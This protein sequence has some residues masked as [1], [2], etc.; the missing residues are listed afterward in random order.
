MSEKFLEIR[1]FLF[2]EYQIVQ[3]NDPVSK[4]QKIPVMSSWHCQHAKIFEKKSELLKSEILIQI[5]L[6][7]FTKH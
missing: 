3:K 7:N 6:S 5:G 1:D 2:C 4:R